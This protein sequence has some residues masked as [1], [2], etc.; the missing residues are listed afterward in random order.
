MTV[1]EATVAS[2]CISTCRLNNENICQGCYRSIDEIMQWIEL[3]DPKRLEVLQRCEERRKAT[4][5]D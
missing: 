4:I 5:F 2:P 1:T 3:P